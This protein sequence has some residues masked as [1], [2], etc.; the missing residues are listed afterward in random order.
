VKAWHEWALASHARR[1]RKAR[2]AGE[3]SITQSKAGAG[4]SPAPAS[5][6]GTVAA[7]FLP[8]RASL[9]SPKCN[10][11]RLRQGRKVERLHNVG[12]RL[13]RCLRRIRCGN[14]QCPQPVHTLERSCALEPG[15]ASLR[16]AGPRGD[17]AS[18]A[19]GT[20]VALRP[21]SSAARTGFRQ[22]LPREPSLATGVDGQ[23]DLREVCRARRTR[24]GGGL[25]TRC[26]W[27]GRSQFG[28]ARADIV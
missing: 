4:S 24:R 12:N 3:G 20:S 25:E 15:A 14:P 28:G 13:C 21:R 22:M 16:P 2:D 6:R 1:S 18:A 9:R 8:T 7:P 19:L 5:W 26:V 10:S 23:H 17:Q 27:L 11:G